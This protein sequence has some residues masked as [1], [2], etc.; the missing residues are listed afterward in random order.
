MADVVFVVVTIA[1]FA[2]CAAFVVGCDK[3]IGPD[4]EY[5]RTDN[6]QVGEDGESGDQN[7]VAA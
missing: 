7:A 1:F 4:D 5:L 3:L 2:L 6:G